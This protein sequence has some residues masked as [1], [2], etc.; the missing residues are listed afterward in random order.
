MINPI[1]FVELVETEHRLRPHWRKGQTYF[2]VL[3][4]IYPDFANDI[5]G[6]EL[7]P[8]HDDKKVKPFMDALWELYHNCNI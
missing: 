4:E 8:F 5:R 7:D 2:N 6:T 3:Y 1:H